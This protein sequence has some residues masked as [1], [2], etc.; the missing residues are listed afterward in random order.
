MRPKI[1]LHQPIESMKVEDQD[2]VFDLTHNNDVYIKDA[3]G[4]LWQVLDNRD[5]NNQDYVNANT[6]STETN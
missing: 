1:I 3:N 6:T 2:R 5:Y 4:A